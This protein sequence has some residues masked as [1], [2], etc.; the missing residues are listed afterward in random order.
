MIKDNLKLLDMDEGSRY[1]FERVHKDLINVAK[2]YGFIVD[3]ATSDVCV[4][5][6]NKYG[7]SIGIGDM[8]TE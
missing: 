1:F 7:S 4:R 6:D 8:E 5:L 3:L 2:D